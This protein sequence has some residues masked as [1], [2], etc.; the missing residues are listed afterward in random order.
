MAVSNKKSDQQ[1]KKLVE[2]AAERLAEILIMQI[3]SE[4]NKKKNHGKE[5]KGKI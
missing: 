4:K 3:E 1:K 2:E 5:T